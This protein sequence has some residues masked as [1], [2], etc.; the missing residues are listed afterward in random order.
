MATPFGAYPRPS[1]ASPAFFEAL[2]PFLKH[3]GDK[4]VPFAVGDGPVIGVGFRTH[5]HSLG[6]AMPPLADHHPAAL[7]HYHGFLRNAYAQDNHLAAAHRQADLTFAQAAPPGPFDSKDPL[8]PHLDWLNNQQALAA[9]CLSQLKSLAQQAGFNEVF[10]ALDLAHGAWGPLP[11]MAGLKAVQVLRLKGDFQEAEG[12]ADA[13]AFLNMA[14]LFGK[15]VVVN[16]PPPQTAEETAPTALVFRSRLD[17]DLSVIGHALPTLSDFTTRCLGLEPAQ[18]HALAG[19][20]GQFSTPLMGHQPFW[21]GQMTQIYTQALT[22]LGHR[23]AYADETLGLDTLKP[24][25]L[26]VAPCL[27]VMERP[28]AQHLSRLAAQGALVIIGPSPPL[29]D[30]WGKPLSW[31]PPPPTP[32]Q[33]DHQRTVSGV[34]LK[35][36]WLFDGHRLSAPM[37]GA[38]SAVVFPHGSGFIAYLTGVSGGTPEQAAPVFAGFL[39]EL[40]G[41]V[42]PPPAETPP[43]SSP[44]EA[45]AAEET[46]ATEAPAP[47]FQ[48]ETPPAASLSMNG[49][50]VVDKEK[51]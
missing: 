29:C 7:A 44:A 46:P 38:A 47:T 4:T 2:W 41:R 43:A 32:T 39:S 40:V 48:M 25:A 12:T 51:T 42:M 50:A 45:E 28:V 23:V 26:V 14:G 9:R 34:D 30:L 31:L 3:L 16:H 18:R 37:A 19:A 5:V 22:A 10:F 20:L 24:A 27:G 15:T 8:L 35:E 21:F 49:P 33:L 11:A 17:E 6:H 1:E 36:E 13:E